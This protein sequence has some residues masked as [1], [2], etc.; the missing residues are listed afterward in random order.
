MPRA[1]LI[2]HRRYN[3]IE[4][5][6]DGSGRDFSPERGVRLADYSGNHPTSDGASECGSE[7]SSECPEELYNLTKLAE[8]SLAAAAGTLIHPSNVIFQQPASPRCAQYTDRIVAPRSKQQESQFTDHRTMEDEQ[9]LGERTRLFFERIETEREILQSHTE[10]ST[11]LGIHVSPHSHRLQEERRLEVSDNSL[12]KTELD[13]GSSIPSTIPQS[14]RTTSTSTETSSKSEDTEDHECPDC[15]KKYSTSSNLARHRQT[16][17]SLGDKKARRCPHCDKVY[18]SMPAFSMHVRTHNQGCKCHYCGKC[19]SRPWLLQGHI[20]THTGEKPFKCTICN[21]AF[22]D[23]SNLR[24][25]IQTHSNTKPHVCGR[26][27]KAFA[28]KSYLY[29]HEESSCMRAHH[30]SSGEK[31]DGTDQKTTP[32]A[33]SCPPLSTSLNRLPTTPC[34]TASPTS[35]IVPRLGLNRD[36]RNTSSAFSAIIRHTRIQ[37]TPT[38]TQASKRS[39]R[40]KTP[41]EEPGRKTPDNSTKDQ[42]CVSRMVIR[43]SV[44]SPNPEHLSRFSNDSQNSS[45][46]FN[47]SDPTRSSA[48]SRPTTMTLNLAIA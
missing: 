33:R 8:V 3:G 13:T 16:H 19:F 42:E 1:F 17:R 26:C 35:V 44:I 23:K 28:L 5:E 47:F 9:T 34:V 7:T 4:E 6:F 46:G 24:A 2:T 21:K 11:V 14:R 32:S 15:G 37:D 18:V 38:V 41:I 22:A 40:E 39:C 29:K 36:Q 25:H 12:D 27:G 45:N 10:R 20:R 48:F 43:T 30:R 31:T